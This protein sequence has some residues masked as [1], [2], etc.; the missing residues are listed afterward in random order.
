M[1]IKNGVLQ[2]VN[3]QGVTFKAD[4]IPQ[5]KEVIKNGHNR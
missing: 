4:I 5:T 1:I 3:I 2:N